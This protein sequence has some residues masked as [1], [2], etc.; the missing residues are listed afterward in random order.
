MRIRTSSHLSC[1]YDGAAHAGTDAWSDIE[2]QA[3]CH[4]EHARYIDEVA[5]SSS[6]QRLSTLLKVKYMVSSRLTYLVIQFRWLIA[7]LHFARYLG[8][9]LLQVLEAQGQSVVAPSDRSGLH[10]LVVP[11]SSG[12][13]TADGG[14]SVT[15]LLRWP[16]SASRVGLP[17][18]CG[19]CAMATITLTGAQ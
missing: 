8:K 9:L 7:G 17:P 11:L 13:G 16:D 5:V 4:A 19:K 6:P 15:G 12:S 1:P 2:V 14:D 10:P 18:S 3:A